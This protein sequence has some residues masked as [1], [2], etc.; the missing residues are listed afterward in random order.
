M[1]NLNMALTLARAS[2][3]AYKDKQTIN[4][5]LSDLNLT[6]I[7]HIAR[8]DTECF[9][10]SNRQLII[11]AFRGTEPGSLQDWRTDARFAKVSHPLGRVHAGFMRALSHV[12]DEVVQT[13]QILRPT[14]SATASAQKALWITGHSLG[15]ALAMLAAAHLAPSLE[16]VNGLATFGQPRVGNRSFCRQLD[17]MLGR[18]Y[19]RFVNNND[20][21][22]RLPGWL[23]GY[24]H[25]GQLHYIDSAG[26]LR[27]RMD[28]PA[29]W[30]D[31]LG[32]ALGDLGQ[33]G[34]DAIKDHAINRNIWAIETAIEA[35]GARV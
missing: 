20:L 16:F 21:V 35:G 33:P 18:Q 4:A 10:A 13:I 15:G 17:R 30:R 34:L 19:Q 1:K 27:D 7:K 5:H 24:R 3:L 6:Q 23:V 11:L 2:S 28:W 25:A 32:G 26:R 9:V 22:P 12:E 31:R 14:P 29:L 8:N